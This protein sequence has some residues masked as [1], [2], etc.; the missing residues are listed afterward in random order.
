MVRRRSFLITCSSLAA[1]PAVPAFGGAAP[2]AAVPSAATLPTA[3]AMPSEPEP[4]ELRIVG[5]DPRAPPGAADTGIWV[6][7]S[8]SW[9]VAWR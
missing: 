9:Q 2:D 8:S 1:A 5:W 3:A 4:P 6:Q 7:V